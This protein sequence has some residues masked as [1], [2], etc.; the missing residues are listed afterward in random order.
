[1]FGQSKWDFISQVQNCL[2]NNE[3]QKDVTVSGIGFNATDLGQLISHESQ[4]SRVKKE[5]AAPQ[6]HRQLA[7]EQR[8]HRQEMIK[9]TKEK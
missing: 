3:S 9:V 2:T 6:F 5:G 7:L 8:F 4:L 1:M